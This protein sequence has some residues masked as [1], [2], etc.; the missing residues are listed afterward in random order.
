[1]RVAPIAGHSALCLGAR[2]SLFGMLPSPHRPP[3]AALD[4]SKH[5]GTQHEA[6]YVGLGTLKRVYAHIADAALVAE[7]ARVDAKPHS[8]SAHLCKQND[9]P[10]LRHVA[11]EPHARH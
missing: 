5:D 7:K 10:H 1:M 8:H 2:L 9:R 3:Y 4:C 6:S 11:A